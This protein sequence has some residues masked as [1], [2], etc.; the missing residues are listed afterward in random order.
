MTCCAEAEAAP[1]TTEIA[2]QNNHAYRNLIINITFRDENGKRQLGMSTVRF[3]NRLA[4][5]LREE[6]SH[7]EAPNGGKN[8]RNRQKAIA[9]AYHGNAQIVKGKT[10]KMNEAAPLFAE[11]AGKKPR[12]RKRRPHGVIHEVGVPSDPTSA[13]SDLCCQ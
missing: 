7:R 13:E 3:S 4:H 1:S 12:K 10:L 5:P 9:F 6:E 11:A 8:E 2:R